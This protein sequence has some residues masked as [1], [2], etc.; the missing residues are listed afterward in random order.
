ML[1]HAQDVIPLL[2]W[3]VVVVGGALLTLLVWTWKRVQT[4]VDGLPD[5][6]SEKVRLVHTEIVAEMKTMNATQ[7]AL[8]RD[9]RGQFAKLDRRVIRL[10]VM[11]DIRPRPEDE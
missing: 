10:E 11:Q 5:Q 4:R 3:M 6:I 8:E 9:L 1:E 2:L 7:A